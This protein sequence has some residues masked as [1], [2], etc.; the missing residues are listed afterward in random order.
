MRNMTIFK[1]ILSFLLA[2]VTTVTVSG[3]GKKEQS[4]DNSS[5]NTVI[6]EVITNSTDNTE[7]IINEILEGEISKEVEDELKYNAENLKIIEIFDPIE[8]QYKHWIVT[9]SECQALGSSF[10]VKREEFDFFDGNIENF[11]GYKYYKNYV[12]IQDK[13]DYFYSRS[14]GFSGVL[15]GTSV[16]GTSLF[17]I[18]T[19]YSDTGKNH[20][21]VGCNDVFNENDVLY[22]DYKDFAIVNGDTHY[23]T[24]P[25][26]NIKIHDFTSFYGEGKYSQ[27]ELEEILASFDGE[28]LLEVENDINKKIK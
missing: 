27:S 26:Y 9:A 13:N 12:S 16:W 1:R 23:R 19:D 8:K 2:G 7:D 10:D 28:K 24:T 3:C 25:S 14:T 4:D 20:Y 17:E 5:N 15:D 6:E 22:Y 18:F 21:I 11:Q